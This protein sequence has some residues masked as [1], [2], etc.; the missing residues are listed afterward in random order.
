MKNIIKIKA[1]N[2]GTLRIDFRG[3][4]KKY[5]GERIPVW[6]DYKSIKI[7]GKEILS[8][9]VETW[10]DKPFKYEM[11]VKDGQKIT[12]E[13]EQQYHEYTDNEIKDVIMKLNSSSK[14]IKEYIDKIIDTLKLSISIVD[15]EQRKKKQT[16]ALISDLLCDLLSYRINIKNLGT[17]TNGTDIRADNAVVKEPKWFTNAEG[18]GKTVSGHTMKNTIKIKAINDGTLRMDFRGEDKRY[19]DERIPVWIDY[20]SVKIDGEEILS[21]PVATWHDKPYRYEMPVKDGQEITLEIK[22]KY[23]EY[24]EN[25]LKETL[26]KLNITGEEQLTDELIKTIYKKIMPAMEDKVA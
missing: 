7:D 14:F 18:K 17:S 16:E 11:P 5:N 21:M 2:D 12:V 26:S 15:E 8:T 6:I 25:E 1:I 23:H 4:D 24:T 10:H 13:Y 19:K 20:K 3:E 9:P 22:Q